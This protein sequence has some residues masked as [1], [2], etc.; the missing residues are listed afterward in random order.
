MVNTNESICPK[1][2]G[3][4]KYYDSVKRIVRTK[5]RTTK[6][7]FLRRLRCSLCHS[8]HRE[9]PYFI[10]PYKQYEKE[11]II[12]VLEKLITPETLGYEDYPCE[13]TMFRWRNSHKK[14][15]LL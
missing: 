14:Q 8:V 4:L 3:Q 15:L 1:C 5:Q 2:G 12:G 9:I 13:M 11:I 7:I 6:K 10:F